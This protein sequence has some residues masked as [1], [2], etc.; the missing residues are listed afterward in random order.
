MARILVVDDEK[1]IRLTFSKILER[2][3]YIVETGE[4]FSTAVE[5]MGRSSFDT[6]LVDIILPSTSGIELLKFIRD[7]FPLIPV[8]MI[9]GQPNLKTATETVRYGAYDYISKPI[10]KEE[11]LRI[12]VRATEKKRILDEKERLEEEN[13][14]YR[15]ELE[16][17]VKERTREVE[18]RNQELATLNSIISTANQTLNIHDTLSRALE[19]MV[20]LYHSNP[21]L[22]YLLENEGRELKPMV[23]V[24]LA[25]EEIQ[26]ITSCLL[27]RRSNNDEKGLQFKD[28]NGVG[29]CPF[30][31]RDRLLSP[32]EIAHCKDV[33]IRSRRGVMGGICIAP[34][35]GVGLS[36]Q[37]KNKDFILTLA[38]QMAIAIENLRLYDQLSQEVIYLKNEVR[39]KYSFENIIGKSKGMQEVFHT[40]S[41]VI[42]CSVTVMLRGESGTGKGLIAKTIHYSGERQDKR[43]VVQNC[44]AIP[45]SMLESE[46]FGHKKGSFT[47]AIIDKKGLFEVADG[48]TIFLDEIGDTSPSVQAKLL[49]VLEEGEIRRLG[50]TEPR[51]VNVRIISATSKDLEKEMCEGRFRRELYYRLNVITIHI[52]PLR[53]RK[54]DIPLLAHHSLK[55]FC[56]SSKKRISGF[57]RR[58]MNLLMEYQWPGNVRQLENE[59][60]RAVTLVDDNGIIDTHLFSDS[61]RED[62]ISMD[63]PSLKEGAFKKRLDNFKKRLIIDCLQETDNNKAK[64]ADILGMPRP[65]LIRIIRRLGIKD[66]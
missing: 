14:K 38:D 66:I 15:E 49:R 13:Q 24:G 61:L 10:V 53:D 64:A 20:N 17:R 44:A 59:I 6:V 1:S 2:E 7:R 26:Y 9:T 55:R 29:A 41:K 39:G 57:S 19:Q 32:E 63:N 4:D 3:G 60:E 52:P 42:P 8:I 56:E 18:R 40:M 51:K 43:F 54:D 27:K 31:R 12:V 28:T 36:I 23:H 46:L 34:Q 11:L 50:D 5:A 35:P 16:Q 65:S 45:E 62:D 33:P 48:G 25:P 37:M 22:I 58:A 30:N 21:I 47:G